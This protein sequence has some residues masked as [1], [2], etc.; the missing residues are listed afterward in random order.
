MAYLLFAC[1]KDIAI[2][3]KERL[4]L[5]NATRSDKNEVED[6]EKSQLER[7]GAVSNLPKGESAE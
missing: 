1:L 2:V 6:G 4:H 7:K 3:E 5:V